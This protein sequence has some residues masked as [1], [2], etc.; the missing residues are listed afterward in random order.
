MRYDTAG[1]EY[2][3]QTDSTGFLLDFDAGSI[4]VQGDRNGKI[5]KLN[6]I[7]P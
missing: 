6:R 7:N 5:F 3:S 1:T 4:I 2:P